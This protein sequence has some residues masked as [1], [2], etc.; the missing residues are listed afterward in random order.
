MVQDENGRL[1][2]HCGVPKLC[3]RLSGWFCIVSEHLATA[4]TFPL[5]LHICLFGVVASSATLVHNHPSR[6][7][8]MKANKVNNSARICILMK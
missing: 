5:P 1:E 3:P 6:A 8:G 4:V 2:S 7:L